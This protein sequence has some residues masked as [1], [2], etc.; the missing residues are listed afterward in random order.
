VVSEEPVAGANYLSFPAKLSSPFSGTV[1][2]FAPPASNIRY[3]DLLNIRGKIEPPRNSNEPWAVFPKQISAISHGNGF[4][5]TERLL[6]FKEAISKKFGEFLPQDEAALQSGMTLGGTAGMGAT[7][8]SEMAASETLYVT[9]MYGYKI[10][11][12]LMVMEASLASFIP[13]RVRFSIAALMTVLFVLM[14]GNNVSAVRGGV[15]ACVLML[16]KETGSV[17]SKRS[18]LAFTAA[19][20]AL[21]DPSVVAQAGFLFSFLSVAGMALLVGPLGKFLHLGEGKG[22]FMWKEAILLSVASLLPIIPLISTIYGSFSLTAV[23]ANI[24]IAPAIPLGMAS[25]VALALAGFISS[26]AAFFIA[27]AAGPVLDYAL[28]VVHFFAAHAVPLPFSFSG[29]M[30]FVLY[31]AAVGLFAYAYRA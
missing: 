5:L 14:S 11:M 24:L 6:D 17:F 19:G 15:M 7:L 25:G 22:I 27:R 10:A 9:S 12:I 2:I 13:R 3:G 23:F 18:A 21:F 26:Y 31:Y 16:A 20:M 4:W 29:A 8:K 1:K 28:S 30:P